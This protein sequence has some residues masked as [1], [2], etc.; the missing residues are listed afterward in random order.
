MAKKESAEKAGT[1]TDSQMMAKAADIGVRGGRR[2]NLGGRQVPG[3]RRLWTL[4]DVG[5]ISPPR[6]ENQGVGSSI[7]P[8]A[9]MISSSHLL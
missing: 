5:G 3:N 2:W 9:T 1:D 4:V 6:P 8:W 7:L